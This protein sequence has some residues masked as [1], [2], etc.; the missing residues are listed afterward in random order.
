MGWAI[1]DGQEHG[2]DPAWDAR[3][4]EA[5]YDLL[6]RE[7]VPEFYNARCGK[8]SPRG[9][10]AKMRESMARLAPDFSA[11]RA[12]REYTERYYL[13][14]ASAYHRRAEDGGKFGAELLQWQREIAA[15]WPHLRFGSV[16]VHHR[17][18]SYEFD[19]QVYLNEL[20]PDFVRVELYADAK[21]GGEPIRQTMD[22]THP[23]TGAGNAYVF[24]ARVPLNRA[25]ED[26]T[27][28]IVPFKEEAFLPLEAAQILWQR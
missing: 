16:T 1:G 2:D 27:P 26:Y 21:E 4:A 23:L 22:R 17:N 7:V 5:L 19:V 14:A 28:R 24:S 25:A 9:W 11:N 3:E 8:A 18:D 13:R 12:V 15:H 6:E 20:N 10:V